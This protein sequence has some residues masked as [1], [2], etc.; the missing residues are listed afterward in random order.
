MD[1]HYVFASTTGGGLLRKHMNQLLNGVAEIPQAHARKLCSWISLA[2]ELV[3]LW[4]LRI[5]V[6]YIPNYINAISDKITCWE[7]E[8][9]PSSETAVKRFA[10]ADSLLRSAFPAVPPILHVVASVVT[11]VVENRQPW[12]LYGNSEN[13]TVILLWCSTADWT[14]WRTF[15]SQTRQLLCWSGG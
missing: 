5:R 12:E 3:G 15:K 10:F 6:S 8:Q 11:S 13:L 9:F 7:G 2:I 14:E 1:S 4:N